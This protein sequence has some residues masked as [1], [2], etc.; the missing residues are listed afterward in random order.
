MQVGEHVVCVN[1][2]FATPLAK[3]YRTLPV[4]GRTYTIR[5]V[6]VGRGVMHPGPGA[7]EGLIGLLLDELTNGMDPRHKYKQELGFNSERFRPLQERDASK[8]TEDELVMVGIS[9]KA[10]PLK[11]MAL[12]YSPNPQ[13]DES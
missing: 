11:E 1:D 4:K 9:L 3:R 10:N 12:P 2:H 7:E 8:E 6:F 5:A 13:P